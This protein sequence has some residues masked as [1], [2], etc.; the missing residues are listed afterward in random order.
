V[1]DIYEMIIAP[2]RFVIKQLAASSARELE[3]KLEAQEQGGSAAAVLKDT[4]EDQRSLFQVLTILFFGGITAVLVWASYMDATYGGPVHGKGF[5]FPAGVVP[6][7]VIP[8]AEGN[9][10]LP[11]SCAPLY[12]WYLEPLMSSEKKQ[13]MQGMAPKVESKNCG[14]TIGGEKKECD[15]TTIGGCVWTAE[16]LEKD[17]STWDRRELTYWERQ[18]LA[19][20]P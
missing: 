11:C 3:S 4:Q 20:T 10:R 8:D 9:A 14:R 12:K 5:C 19:K 16:D 18:R 1:G 7:Y 13:S 2:A 17:P 6:S 15:P